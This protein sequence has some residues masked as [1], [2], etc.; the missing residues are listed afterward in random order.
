MK[1]ISETTGATAVKTIRPMNVL[2]LPSAGGGAEEE[3]LG[4]AD[5]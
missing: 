4:E 3:G 2:H 5:D 1:P